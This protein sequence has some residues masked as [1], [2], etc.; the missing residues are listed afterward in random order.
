MT[1]VDHIDIGLLTEYVR[2]HPIYIAIL[3]R[4]EFSPILN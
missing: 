2:K 4:L 1:T 3:S